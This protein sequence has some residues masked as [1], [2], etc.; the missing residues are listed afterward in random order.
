MNAGRYTLREFLC[1][2]NLLQILI[3]E[4]QRDYVWRTDNIEKLLQ[5][6][7]EDSNKKNESDLSEDQMQALPVN[8]RELVAREAEKNKVYANIGFVYA[9][10]DTQYDGRYMLIDG[11][12]RITTLLLL[13]LCIYIKEG[14]NDLFSRTYF[15]DGLPKVDYKV[16][17]MSH[18]FLLQFTQFLLEGGKVEEVKNQYWYYTKYDT[19]TT[20]KSI[21]DNYVTINKTLST[22]P[23]SLEFIENQVEFYYFDTNKSE[24]GEELYLYM[25][26]RG[27]SV[28]TNENIKADLLAG[29]SEKEKNDWGEK[30]ENWQDFFWKNRGA[31]EN[32]DTGFNEL[33]KCIKIINLVT[34]DSSS[35]LMTLTGM[36][37][38]LI[39]SR[40]FGKDGLTLVQIEAFMNALY[41]INRELDSTLFKQDWLNGKFSTID[42]VKFLP[43]LTYVVKNP[44]C[45]NHEIKRYARFFFN[46]S[47]FDDVS[48][49]PYNYIIYT[50]QL[51]NIFLAKGYTDVVDLRNL[52][53]EGSFDN[54]LTSEEV[55]KLSIFHNPPN[56]T[57]REE[58][59]ESFWAGEDFKLFDGTISLIWLCMGYS[60]KTDGLNSFD[61]VLFKRYLAII[62]ELFNNPTD[63]LRRSLLTQ[64][65]YSIYDGFTTSF[66]GERYS[67]INDLKGWKALFD[68]SE[69]SKTVIQ[70]LKKYYHLYELNP[71]LRLH[72]LLNQ[73]IEEYL[74]T[75]KEMNW[76]YYFIKMPEVLECCTQKLV[77]FPSRETSHIVLLH[78]RKA[79]LNNWIYLEEQIK[80]ATPND[81]F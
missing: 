32:A 64:G 21:F 2:H 59:E 3:P 56:S 61:I 79:M 38:Q 33:L 46:I 23:I 58:I 35:G 63:L 36:V 53:K 81:F 71:T 27:E 25:N 8:V 75:N 45:Q 10:Y 13:L 39:D 78:D 48:K 50:L 19:D 76:I 22:R 14:K 72:Q 70:L 11:Q 55:F 41:I 67:F 16:R 51:T 30:W 57:T 47:R 40:G 69:K 62:K 49:V 73:I 44:S 68:S 80:P 5:S 28:Q 17:E 37:R 12:Q 60:F 18:D 7:W 15:K 74:S 24:Q 1:N 52:S 65:D 66:N 43:V 31:N 77:C 42:Y 34:T 20:I 29:L 26:S 9:Y 4:I 54:I 6:L